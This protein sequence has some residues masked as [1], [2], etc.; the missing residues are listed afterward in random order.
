MAGAVQTLQGWVC[1]GTH[2]LAAACASLTSLLAVAAASSAIS[3]CCLPHQAATSSTNLFR[4][5]VNLHP[6]A[7]NSKQGSRT[8]ATIRSR[9]AIKLSPD[10]A[11]GK[12]I[13]AQRTQHAQP[14]VR[15]QAPVAAG[16][17]GHERIL[18]RR[19]FR[20]PGNCR[21]RLLLL[22]LLHAAGVVVLI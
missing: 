16:G 18:I 4:G 9:A 21:R 3:M 6:V 11:S 14:D 22:L 2:R 5:Y 10:G 17:V 8:A 13:V 15:G 1:R 20:L 12:G 19:V 7:W